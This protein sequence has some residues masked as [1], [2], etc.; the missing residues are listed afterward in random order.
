MNNVVHMGGAAQASTYGR[1]ESGAFRLDA[2]VIVRKTPLSSVVPAYDAPRNPPGT[3]V[4]GMVAINIRERNQRRKD[5]AIK[6]KGQELPI[7]E[8]C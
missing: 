2:L 7:R 1:D 5:K 4:S 3:G 6:E 8:E